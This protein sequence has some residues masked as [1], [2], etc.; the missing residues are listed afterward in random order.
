MY[1]DDKHKDAL[2]K[3]LKDNP[4]VSA[5]DIFNWCCD[6]DCAPYVEDCIDCEHAMT[7]EENGGRATIEVSD[8]MSGD[9]V[10]FIN[11][12]P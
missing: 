5:S 8:P 12:K 3:H 9:E 6:N 7:P 1:I 10:L 2:M 11:G 4:N